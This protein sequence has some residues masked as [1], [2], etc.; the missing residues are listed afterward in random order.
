MSLYIIEPFNN[1]GKIMIKKT[2]SIR[3]LRKCQVTDRMGYGLSTL[4]KRV[5]AGVFPPSINLGERA[6][7]WFE[8]EVTEVLGE[9]SQG[10]TEDDM[11]E[12][13]GV[14]LEK[15]KKISCIGEMSKS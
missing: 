5:K 13:V 15:R 1:Q 10:A 3:I 11:R 12:L 9:L 7:G 6:V 2:L 4:N 14:L 8:Y